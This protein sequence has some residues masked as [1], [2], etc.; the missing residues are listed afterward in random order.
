MAAG[1]RRN[2]NGSVNTFATDD[3]GAKAKDFVRTYWIKIA[4]A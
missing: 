1:E 4:A 2:G 3:T